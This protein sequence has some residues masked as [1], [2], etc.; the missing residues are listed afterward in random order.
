MSLSVG[1]QQWIDRHV[2]AFLCRILS[3][4]GWLKGR[5]PAD[6]KSGNI[7][8]TLLTEM[9]CLVLAKPM[10]EE[11][12]TRYPE[13]EIHILVFDR[14]TGVLDVLDLV[15]PE[16]VIVVRNSS[17]PAFVADSLKALRRIRKAKIRTL[18]DCELFSRVSSI[19]S[20]LS[21]ASIRVGFHPLNQEGLY[22]GSFINRRVQY[23]PH[24]HIMHQ[25]R[26]LAA[27]IP[28]GTQPAGK[29]IFD[30]ALPELEPV[31]FSD[32]E[33]RQYRDELEA[34]HPVVKDRKLILV[35]P[36]GGLLPIRAWPLDRFIQ[37]CRA[38]I[39]EGHAV[40]IVGREVE[41]AQ[42]QQILAEVDSNRC[43]D[44]V[45][46]TP[47]IRHF[48]ILLHQSSLLLTNDGGP[49]HFA[50]LTPMPAIV[51]FGPETPALYGPLGANIHNLAAD[52]SC[53]PCVT[54]FNH[55]RSACDGDNQC[56]KAISVDEV[57]R[58]MRGCLEG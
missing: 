48:L 11:L 26:T 12:K 37:V 29:R 35:Y 55:K 50:S 19:F 21:G 15:P 46:Y 44:L 53:S 3:V 28:A 45:H 49:G 36:G 57:L 38:M 7:L 20:I 41:D 52:C 33:L 10:F 47:T 9:G 56:L 24:L 25:Y 4:L 14:S 8:V 30:S 43:L 2:G 17:F 23:N 6:H 51:L 22:R 5:G 13:A 54:A 58:T 31:S 39:D 32:E 40:A 18:V 27:A 1:Q 34:A 16:N 42:L